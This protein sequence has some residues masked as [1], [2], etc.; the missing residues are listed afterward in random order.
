MEDIEQNPTID[1][2]TELQ[3]PAEV[4]PWSMMENSPL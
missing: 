3:T 1:L 2:G 4:R